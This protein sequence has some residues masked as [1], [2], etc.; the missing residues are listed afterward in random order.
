M[1]AKAMGSETTYVTPLEA[2]ELLGVTVAQ[3]HTLNRNGLLEAHYPEGRRPKGLAGKKFL[4]E[5]VLT[6]AELRE[7][8]KGALLLKLPQ[9]ALRAIVSSKRV[10]RRLD[11]IT[12]YLGLND[13]VLGTEKDDVLGLFLRA[14]N[15]LRNPKVRSEEEAL[16]WAK[17]LL[18]MTEEYLELTE[19]HSGQPEPWRVFLELAKTLSQECSPGTA[20]R[21]YLDHARSNLRRVS[22][23]HLRSAKGSKEADRVFPGEGYSDRLLR[24]LF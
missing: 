24:T 7:Q 23:F 10:E 22:Y 18:A 21:M 2:S 13:R 4:R 11:E 16:D 1:T 17:N 9:L 3:V 5:D 15:F 20:A 8:S 14:E 6:L 12:R 19:A